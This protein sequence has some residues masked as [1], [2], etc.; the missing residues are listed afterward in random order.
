M[1]DILYYLLLYISQQYQSSRAVINYGKE[2]G[3]RDG[4]GV[5][6]GATRMEPV[7]DVRRCVLCSAAP[8]I[9]KKINHKRNKLRSEC[10]LCRS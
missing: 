8:K 1:R 3:G 6:I 7:H 4:G 9:L 5:G 2:T 10:R